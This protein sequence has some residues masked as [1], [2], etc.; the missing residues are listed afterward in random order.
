[1]SKILT[2]FGKRL[3]WRII[4]KADEKGIVHVDTEFYNVLTGD[5]LGP[6]DSRQMILYLLQV[7]RD[8]CAV[9]FQGMQGMIG[10]A[11]DGKEGSPGDNNKG[12]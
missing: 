11:I 9:M 3:Q 6:L 12:G 7:V 8:Y 4:V 2:P 5:L 1:M 10:G